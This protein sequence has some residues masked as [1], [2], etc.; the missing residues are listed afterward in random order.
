MTDSSTSSPT[1]TFIGPRT[2]TAGSPDAS[3]QAATG[4][5]RIVLGL[6][7]IVFGFVFLWAFLDKTF[8]LGFA[9]P[10]ESAWIAGGSPTA[11]FLSST[12]GSFAPLFH[13][14]AGQ[15]WVDWLFMLGML[16]TGLAFVAGI[17][18]PVAASAAVLIMSLMWLASFPLETNPAVDEHIV[19]SLLAIM[20]ALTH[21]G[22]SW[23]VPTL[24][25]Q[26]RLVVPGRLRWAF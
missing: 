14:L 26:S 21:A 4:W 6:T 19:Y 15:P 3:P 11:G 25:A 23:G 18:L 20:L 17:A 7:R 10:A 12:A 1:T 9:T 24:L 5:G 8:G 22:R 13:A 16:G 2:D